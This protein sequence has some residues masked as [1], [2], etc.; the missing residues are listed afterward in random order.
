MKKRKKDIQQDVLLKI[1]KQFAKVWM[2]FDAKVK[3]IFHGDFSK[4]RQTPY[5]LLANHTFLFDVVHVPLRLRKTPFIIASHNLFTT[6]PTKF[7]L[8]EI[9]HAIPKSKGAS[10][11]RAARELIG[12][13]K[14]GYPI[15][16]FPEG[17][18]TFNG[19][20]N[21]IEEATM[22]LIKKLKV[23]VIAC[24]V[25]GGYLSKP[26]WATGKRKKR[27]IQ[28]D[29][30]KIIDK[31][32]LKTMP[33]D[34][35]S[36]K[37]NEALYFN[38][39]EYQRKHMIKHPGK[40]LAEGI[41]NLLYLCP[42]CHHVNTIEAEGNTFY[43]THCDTIG[44]YDEY[45]FLN[46]FKFDNTVDWDNYQKEHNHLL[47]NA[48]FSSPA[49]SYQVNSKTYE[50]TFLGNV[51]LTYKDHAF[52]ITGDY[53]MI[54]PFAEVSNPTITLRRDFNIFM[55]DTQYVFKIESHVMAFLRVVQ[56]KY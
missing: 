1:V 44:T 54:L 18:T 50:R 5:V 29:Y 35:I 33:L 37:V 38:A 15:L 53:E 2:L 49:K 9:A 51:T 13:V 24:N 32:D 7:L 34:D 48:A 46:G 8:T 3:A 52:H 28:M 21:Y 26:R 41:D 36:Q 11:I 56:D 45:G 30:F 14:R 43:C 55:K 22:K 17:N 19:E 39:Y 47:L 27:Q 20:T 42:H 25:K 4:K 31:E 6:Q 40:T 10:D 12:A 23:D 16:I